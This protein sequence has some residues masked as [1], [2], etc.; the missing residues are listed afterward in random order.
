MRQGSRRLENFALACVACGKKEEK[1]IVRK[2][3]IV[4]P[5]QTARLKNER[6]FPN[7]QTFTGIGPPQEKDVPARA[8]PHQL[9]PNRLTWD[10]SHKMHLKAKPGLWS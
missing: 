5:P 9:G 10:P 7:K 6:L 3:S 8:A 2:K 4:V 1:I